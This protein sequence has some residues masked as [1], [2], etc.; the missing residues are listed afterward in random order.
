MPEVEN[1]PNGSESLGARIL[2]LD[3]DEARGEIFRSLLRN[4]DCR[5]RSVTMREDAEAVLASRDWDVIFCEMPFARMIL[6][7]MVRQVPVIL[8]ASYA[9]LGEAQRMVAEQKAFGCLPTPI[10][11]EKALQ[12]LRAALLAHP[13]K[14]PENSGD[15]ASL[16]KD[17]SH[18][19]VSATASIVRHFDLMVGESAP[20]Q[21]LY[22]Q[23][24]KVSS[25]DMTVLIL[26]ESG[27]GKEL[28]AKA[29]HSAGNRSTKP[30]I[31]VNCASLP[32]NLL[33][34]ELFGYVKGAFTGAVHNKD[35]LFVAANGGTLFLDEI[36][37]IPMPTQLALLRVLQ[38]REVRPVGST[39]T[40]P[41]DVRVVAATN[42]DVEKLKNEGRLRPDLFYRISAFSLRIP[43]LRER[44]DDI[45]LL[46]KAFL[47]RFT[48]EGGQPL[49]LSSD[50]AT[51]LR[52]HEW[53]GNIRELFHALER[54]ATL[55]EGGVI[56]Q[57]DLAPEFQN[58]PGTTMP[59]PPPTNAD[60]K[61]MTLRAYQRLCERGYL[62]Q[63]LDSLGGDKEKAAKLLGISVA[64]LYRK[65][66]EL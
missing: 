55:S 18:G 43:P 14:R 6:P 45:S 51:A 61:F 37:S 53:R 20:M 27:T 30:F 24:E 46:E 63:V 60:G 21:E 48:P 54:G 47:Q 1:Q 41:V 58:I 50:A 32:E 17:I 52:T 12:M 8:L 3:H 11:S 5:V 31:P 29:I 9:E 57:K 26:G 44:G 39:Q 64:T 36:G 66:S 35:G 33:E 15:N 28:V 62:Q 25:S 38:E 10:R 7:S 56:H 22:H 19:S 4:L 34:S 49:Q 40:I 13:L 16:S 23:I 59:L 2:L 42:E 65:L